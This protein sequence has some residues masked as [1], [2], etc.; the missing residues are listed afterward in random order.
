MKINLHIER[1]VLEGVLLS[2]G[3]RSLLQAAMEADLSRRLANGGLNEGL[4][5]G[6]ALSRVR[7][8]NIQLMSDAPSARL[9]KQIAEAVYGGIG[10]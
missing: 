3:E 8:A 7:T 10:K 4:Q 5:S 2:L 9:G 6:G 1:V